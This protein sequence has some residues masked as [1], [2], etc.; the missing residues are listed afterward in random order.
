[1]NKNIFRG[2]ISLFL[3]L[4][5]AAC[6]T[7]MYEG[8]ER[9][10]NELAMLKS[11]RTYVIQIDGREANGLGTNEAKYQIPPGK[12][13]ILVALNDGNVDIMRRTSKEHRMIQFEASAGRE[14][15]TFP[16]YPDGFKNK[17]WR[18]AVMD[19]VT[20]VVVAAESDEPSK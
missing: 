14:Y 4:S 9:P 8:P 18:V 16:F 6:T 10:A 1:M 12:H 17:K 20:G 13:T 5:L 11:V 19:G 7:A 2:V 15:K 3:P